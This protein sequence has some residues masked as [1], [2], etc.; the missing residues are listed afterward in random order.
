MN[1]KMVMWNVEK[2][3]KEKRKRGKGVW[4]KWIECIERV[5]EWRRMKKWRKRNRNECWSGGEKIW[6]VG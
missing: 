4:M 3:V 6:S 2:Y 5:I 1:E